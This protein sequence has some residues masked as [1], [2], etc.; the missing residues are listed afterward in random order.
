[1]TPPSLLKVA[2]G[3]GTGPD[4]YAALRQTAVDPA[5]SESTGLQGVIAQR[6]RIPALS[7]R[8]SPYSTKSF[9]LLLSGAMRELLQKLIQEQMS[10][11]EKRTTQR[12]EATL[13]GLGMWSPRTQTLQQSGQRAMEAPVASLF[14]PDPSLGQAWERAAM[15]TWSV[16]TQSDGMVGRD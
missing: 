1:M 6:Q 12:M 13:K 4:S 5:E 9:V 16:A 7:H 2:I 14:S 15:A 11:S 3:H 8:E 10:V